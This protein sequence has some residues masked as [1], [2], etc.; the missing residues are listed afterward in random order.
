MIDRSS[1][2]RTVL[3]L[4]PLSIDG[5][6]IVASVS[7]VELA[8]PRR[9]TAPALVVPEAHTA[10]ALTPPAPAGTRPAPTAAAPTEPAAHWS[11]LVPGIGGDAPSGPELVPGP[12]G[13]RAEDTVADA[14]ADA[15]A[16]PGRDGFEYDEDDADD[17][18]A[19]AED[20]CCPTGRPLW[21][22][23]LP[24]STGTT[25][26]STAARPCTTFSPTPPVPR[27]WSSSSTAARW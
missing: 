13:D 3:Y 14:T 7:L 16:G 19:Y 9:D 1:R 26:T 2:A 8:G 12:A 22:K 17:E 23:R 15:D 24:S 25:S 5:L 21:T 4:L 10:A 6:I 20:G 18:D 11:G 27:R